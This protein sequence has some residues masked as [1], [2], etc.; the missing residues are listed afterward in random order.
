M[1]RDRRSGDGGEAD[2]RRPVSNLGLKGPMGRPLGGEGRRW[3]RENRSVRPI[4]SGTRA[5]QST[6]ERALR[7]RVAA[8]GYRGPGGTSADQPGG[9]VG[10]KADPTYIVVWIVGEDRRGATQSGCFPRPVYSRP[11]SFGPSGF[12]PYS[13]GR[14]RCWFRAEVMISSL[15][16]GERCFGSRGRF[17]A[18][19]DQ[20]NRPPVGSTLPHG[21]RFAGH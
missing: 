19:R 15:L 8:S 21:A 18:V 12:G 20:F 5:T 13:F 17:G 11:V 10:R 6:P 1:G 9:G 14:L 3:S 2:D 16:S 4:E 7:Q